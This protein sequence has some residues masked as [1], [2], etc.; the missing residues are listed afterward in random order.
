MYVNIYLH[1]WG[2]VKHHVNKHWYLYINIT[3]TLFCHM[4]KIPYFCYV[5]TLFII[6]SD[7]VTHPSFFLEISIKKTNFTTK[8][9]WALHD[10]LVLTFNFVFLKNF[11]RT[12]FTLICSKFNI[13][14]LF[15]YKYFQ[16][17][18]RL[19]F[20]VEYIWSLRT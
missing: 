4:R 3:S 19:L 12:L 13:L 18:I 14:D 7:R 10:L 5:K 6:H 1:Y 2:E 16:N 15:F 9:Y 8:L 17:C 11:L 20:L